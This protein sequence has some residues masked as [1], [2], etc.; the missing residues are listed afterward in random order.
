MA[1]GYFERGEIYWVRYGDSFG[2]EETAGRPGIIV[3]SNKGNSSSPVVN[4]VLLTT[5][6][7]NLDINVHTDVGG[8]SRWALCNQI[9]T[10]DKTRLLRCEGKLN[11]QEMGE[12]DA[13]LKKVLELDFV[14]ETALK[15]KDNEIKNRDVLIGDLR[16]EMAGVKAE[17]GKKED[18]IAS[19]KMEI[20]MWQ[21]CYGRCMDMLVET[22]VSAD[23]A[24]RTAKVEPKKE[25]PQPPVEEPKP[26]ITEDSPVVEEPES[27]KLDINSCTITAL[28]KAGIVD[29]VATKIVRGRPWK[30]VDDLKGTVGIKATT[31]GIVKEKLCCVAP[32][33]NSALVEKDPGYDE[34]SRIDINAASAAEMSEFFGL[35]ISACYSIVGQRKKN[36][37]YT[38][39][40]ELLTCHGI[41][42]TTVLRIQDKITLSGV[43]PEPLAQEE[44]RKEAEEKPLPELT[45]KLNLNTVTGRELMD[46]LGIGEFYAYTLTA[47]RNRNGPYASVEDIKNVKRIPEIF[48]ERYKDYLTV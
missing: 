31:F 48:Y 47:H 46:K 32:V 45:E 29:G 23:V 5:R 18:E 2:A 35:N 44:P 14:D 12:V 13:A 25:E 22:K 26:E 15:E 27:E 30:S 38:K 16:T 43:I 6:T 24:R 8:V 21:K 9:L 36:G 40:E 41:Y 28:K 37:P 10:V 34:G 1:N 39:L 19:L 3:S 20:E 33:V 42:R 17:I 7:K 4:I 11:S